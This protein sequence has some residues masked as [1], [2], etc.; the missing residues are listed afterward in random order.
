[1]RVS[2]IAIGNEILW[3][4]VREENLFYSSR[5]LRAAG[6]EVVEERIVGDVLD[7]IISALRSC[8]RKTDVIIVSGGLGPTED[9]LTRKAASRLTGKKLILRKEVL[10]ALSERFEKRGMKMPDSNRIQALFPAGSRIIPNP[11]GT[12]PGFILRYKGRRIF[13]LPGVPSEF[14][15]MFEWVLKRLISGGKILRTKRLNVFGLPESEIADRLRDFSSLFPACTISY[16]PSFP[17]NFIDLSILSDDEEGAERVLGDAER[18]IRERLG[19][20]VYSEGEELSEVVGRLL[21]ELGWKLAVAESCTGGLLSSLIT[22]IPGSSDYFAGGGTAYSYPAKSRILNLSL[23]LLEGKGAVN[24]EVAVLMA[25]GALHLLDADVAV[26]TT[27]IL[28]PGKGG[29]KE[30]VGTLYVGLAWKGG[31]FSKKLFFP[32]GERKAKKVLFSYFALDILRRFLLTEKRLR[33]YEAGMEEAKKKGISFVLRSDAGKKILFFPLTGNPPTLAHRKILESAKDVFC[34]DEVVIMVDLQHADKLPEEATLP[35]RI[36]M[37]RRNFEGIKPISIAIV[38]KGLFVEK[39]K[40]LKS[41]YGGEITFLTGMD[42]MERI[43]D[44]SFYRDPHSDW[45]YLFENSR[46]IVAERG[47]MD[48]EWLKG[49]FRSRGLERWLEKILIIKTPPD[50]KEISSTEIRRR[51]K[52]KEDTASL[53][54][55]SVEEFIMERKIYRR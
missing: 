46:F 41:F 11:V 36:E 51:I 5:S 15:K 50:V 33:E 22:D 4:K 47:E 10:K 7:D 35:E 40:I 16:L 32:F 54:H 14:R 43:L 38:E 19:E 20:F 24:E 27:G 44:P 25:E 48:E 49:V 26:S 17:Q 45:K 53:L 29:E 18:W 34:P 1:M 21:R 28:G 39:V 42:A 12:A 55:P 52:R 23:S 30:E 2:L 13:F 31:S 8:A 37:V 6:I 3:G 9:D